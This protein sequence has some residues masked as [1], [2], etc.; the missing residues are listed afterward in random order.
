[1]TTVSQT[2]A[3]MADAVP[4][5]MVDIVV[6]VCQDTWGFIVKVRMNNEV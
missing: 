1:M 2:R 5:V 4:T 6:V 3:K